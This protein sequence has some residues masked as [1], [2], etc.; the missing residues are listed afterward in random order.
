MNT[1]TYSIYNEDISGS[2]P[3]LEG[4]RMG[5]PREPESQAKQ[6]WFADL[7]DSDIINL[8]NR[9]DVMI[10]DEWTEKLGTRKKPLWKTHPPQIR[11]CEK[12]RRFRQS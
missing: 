6:T 11:L 7:S 9:Y 12:G 2:T 10:L 5:P 3:A 4:A 8:S 1:R